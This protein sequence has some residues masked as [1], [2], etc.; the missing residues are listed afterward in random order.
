MADADEGGLQEGSDDEEERRRRQREQKEAEEA[1]F[2]A[3]EEQ[4]AAELGE[5]AGHQRDELAGQVL[6]DLADR[7]EGFLDR[8]KKQAALSDDRT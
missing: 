2:A 3:K 4:E 1:Q 7:S 8:L 6:G 5:S